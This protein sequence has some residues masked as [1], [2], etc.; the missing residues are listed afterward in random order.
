MSAAEVTCFCRYFGILFGDLVP[1]ENQYFEMYLKL[2]EVV[3]IVTSPTLLFGH[4]EHLAILVSEFN[5]MY[6]ELVGD[7]KPKMHFL[8]HYF[9]VIFL[10][11]PPTQYWTMRFESK[12]RDLKRITNNLAGSVNIPKSVATQVSLQMSQ[13]ARNMDF[14]GIECGSKASSQMKNLIPEQY[15]RC[16]T[17][18]MKWVTIKGT[19]YRLNN[20]VV[21]ELTDYLPE[22]GKIVAIFFF[23]NTVMF[24]IEPLSTDS[25]HRHYFAYEVSEKRPSI[26]NFIVHYESLPCPDICP[27]VMK[28]GQQYVIARHVL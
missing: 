27:L 20:V 26:G 1:T 3:D 11:G 6:I 8:T 15:I 23:N 2:R 18:F 7:L 24:S 28:D 22:F 10:F 4:V 16:E 17:W 5:Q 9:R 13:Y 14:T 25:F 19:T 12:H 21:R